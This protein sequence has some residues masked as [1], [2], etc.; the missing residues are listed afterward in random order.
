MHSF[1]RTREQEGLHGQIKS[2]TG[3]VMKALHWGGVDLIPGPTSAIDFLIVP[4]VCQC[5]P[6]PDLL[7]L[8]EE[9]RLIQHVWVE[10]ISLFLTCT[11][12]IIIPISN[13]GSRDVQLV[14]QNR[15]GDNSQVKFSV[16]KLQGNSR[17]PLLGWNR[18][19]TVVFFCPLGNSCCRM[20]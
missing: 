5:K 2:A 20:N 18:L 10:F 19:L 9:T 13:P 15:P 6:D 11:E 3:L 14:H 1:C 16:F 8:M 4:W 12:G 7:K 17:L